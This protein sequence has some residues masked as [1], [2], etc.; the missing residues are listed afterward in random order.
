MAAL[1]ADAQRARRWLLEG[2]GPGGGPGA[3]SHPR[4]VEEGGGLRQAP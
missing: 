2:S 3:S 1:S 4:S